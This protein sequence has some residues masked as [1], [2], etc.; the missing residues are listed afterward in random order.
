M[1]SQYPT[2]TGKGFT[3][4]GAYNSGTAYVPNDVVSSSG[5]SY[6]NILASTGNAPTN[7]TYWSLVASAGSGSAT[8]AGDTDVSITSPANN[9]VLTY[10]S[11][12]SLWKN[13][14][15]SGGG[16]GGTP[17]QTTQRRTTVIA[18]G[19]TTAFTV[20][21]DVLNISAGSKIVGVATATRGI[22]V[23]QNV[24]STYVMFGDGNYVTGRNLKLLV[25]EYLTT[26]G[27]NSSYMMLVEI[28]GLNT[29]NLA[30]NATPSAFGINAFG[31]RCWNKAG[32][33]L[34]TT[35]HAFSSDG[36]ADTFV[37]TGIT[38]DTDSHVFSAIMDDANSQ[39]LYYIDGVLMAT[40]TTNVPAAGKILGLM[41]SEWFAS[42]SPNIGISRIIVD[43]DL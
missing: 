31:F 10:E 2:G 18:D 34:E 32:S 12:S 24:S 3:W 27:D 6:I 43:S 25:Q 14:P 11:S 29:T 40:I 22:A 20:I 41:V 26:T 8:L 17:F 19:Q 16:G 28:S 5:S 1:S 35:W 37:D 21:G 7:A 9:D 23:E 39:I 13:K 4:R 33:S 30:H 15:A 36:S 42:A 38:Q